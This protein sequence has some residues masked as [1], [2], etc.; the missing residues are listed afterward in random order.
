MI[1]KIWMYGNVKPLS[2]NKRVLTSLSLLE[3]FLLELQNLCVYIYLFKIDT[4]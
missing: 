1:T 2:Q 4:S 3:C